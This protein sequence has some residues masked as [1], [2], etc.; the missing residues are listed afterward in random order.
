M[1]FAP[2]SS[3][4][5]LPWLDE[6]IRQTYLVDRRSVLADESLSRADVEQ[7]VGELVDER[8]PLLGTTLR[9]AL[10]KRVGADIAGLGPLEMFLADERVTEVMVNGPDTVFLERDGQLLRIE[11]RIAADI[12]E[13]CIERVIAPLGLRIDRNA[14]YVDARLPDGSRLHAVIPPLALNGPCLTIRKF[15][16]RDIALSAFCE[17]DVEQFLQ[18]S[19]RDRK[20]MLI[21]GATGSGKTTLLSALGELIDDTERV[22]TIEET[23]ELRLKIAN[24]V[25]LEARPPSIEGRGEVT[26]RDLVRNALRMRPDRIIVGEVRGAEAFDMVQ[27]M[28]TGHEGSLCTLH[29]NSADDALA[30]VVVMTLL[31]DVGLPIGAVERQIERAVDLVLQVERTATGRRIVEV[32]EVTRTDQ[33]IHAKPITFSSIEPR[34]AHE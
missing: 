8:E 17:P 25:R 3:L 34:V 7:R 27:A 13:R 26:V 29:A 32:A 15:P 4:N 20:T 2:Q 19:V 23:A 33:G 16:E 31:A 12:I 30:R 5:S 6:E 1:T 11:C 21:S 14:P 9:S 24:I 22:V 28:S 10:I 18:S